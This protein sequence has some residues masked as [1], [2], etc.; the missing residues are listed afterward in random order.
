[1]I[2]AMLSSKGILQAKS[3]SGY[4][5]TRLNR[6]E[7][8]LVFGCSAI[9]SLLKTLLSNSETSELVSETLLNK[10]LLM[11]LNMESKRARESF[12]EGLQGV[13]SKQGLLKAEVLEAIMDM[14]KIK[15]GMADLTLDFD[16]VL[17]ALERV[18][19]FI[20]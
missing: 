11:M 16:K 13:L 10:V 4:I 3:N 12:T 19:L 18:N 15:K 7:E 2:V 9:T 14:N 17:G 20:E 1:M 8:L 5:S 6:N